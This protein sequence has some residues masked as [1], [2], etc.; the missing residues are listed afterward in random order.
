[1]NDDGIRQSLHQLTTP[2]PSES[3]RA[4]ARHRALIAF[5]QGGESTQ[6]AQ[7]LRTGF[8]WRWRGAVA[9]ALVAGLLPFLFHKHHDAPEN[10]AND[11]KILQQV[12]TLFP[13]QVDAV[14]E[15][16][17]KADLSIAQSPVVGSDQPVLV[18]FRRGQDTIRVLSFSGHHVCVMLGRTQSC[19]EI[20]ATPAGGVILEAEDKVWVA[21]EHP[22][23][24]G[25]SVHA[26]ILEASL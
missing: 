23:V 2:E 5:R 22:Q 11:Q 4:R 19:F 25:Y 3:A 12:E 18:L 21:S 8:T 13:N 26:Q 16:N 7:G 17:G 1:M 6:P 15:E 20:L 9:L 10:L 24:S 14:V